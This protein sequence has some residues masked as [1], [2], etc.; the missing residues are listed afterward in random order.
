MT[1]TVNGGP[2]ENLRYEKTINCSIRYFVEND[3]DAFFLAA[4]APGRSAL[5]SGG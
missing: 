1:V 3:L 5:S 4:I 2:G